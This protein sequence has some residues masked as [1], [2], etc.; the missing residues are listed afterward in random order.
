MKQKLCLLLLL[1]LSQITVQS[2][3]FL[4]SAHRGNSSEAPENTLI[5]NELAIDAKADFIECDVRRTRDGVLVL[6]HDSTLDRTTNTR[7]RLRN[8]NYN[9]LANV[10]AGYSRRFGNQFSNERI[11]TLR[12]A[13]VQA[14]GRAKVEIEIK[15]SGLA[16]AVMALVKELN[17]ENDVI[18]IS[19]TFSELQRV[20]QISNIP[21]KYLVS[22]FWGSS[23]LRRVQSIGGEYFGPR[24]VVST[25]RI[26]EAKAMGIEI[27]SYTIDSERDIRRA[28]QNGQRGIATNYP[29]RAYRIR[30]ELQGKS[31]TTTEDI[32]PVIDELDSD[33]VT[34][35]P[36]PTIN[37][38]QI[39]T[40]KISGKVRIVNALGQTVANF[41]IIKNVT[42]YNFTIPSLQSGRY[43]VI[44]ETEASI[45]KLPLL[46]K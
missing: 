19:F 37:S 40:N 5:A 33:E 22:I 10:S 36:N 15:E 13:L 7:G 30:Q 31:V 3:D 12:E 32:L 25:S 24:G 29:R 42:N 34:V 39:K 1:V 28:I 18:I 16:D 9:Q 2:Q 46:I 35:Y 45:E 43:T 41:G 8:F 27:I 44:I 21:I 6:M 23:T 20:K 17:M 38:F 4:I 14:K 11:P 26:R